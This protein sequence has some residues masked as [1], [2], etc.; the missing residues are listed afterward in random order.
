MLK[1]KLLIWV[2]LSIAFVILVVACGSSSIPSAEQEGGDENPPEVQLGERLFLE[3]RF[4]QFFFANSDGDVN[5]PLAVGDPVMD[6]SQT[7]RSRSRDLF[8]ARA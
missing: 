6:T 4:A 8:A 1:S 7:T 2:S 3:T 5:T